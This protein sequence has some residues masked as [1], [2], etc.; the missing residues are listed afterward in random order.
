VKVEGYQDYRKLLENKDVDA[1]IIATPNH[2]H[3]LIAI[4]AAAVPMAS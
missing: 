3:T 2:L 4:A 1:V